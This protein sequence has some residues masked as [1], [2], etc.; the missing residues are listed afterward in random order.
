[1]AT[2]SQFQY[3]EASSLQGAIERLYGT[4]N[5]LLKIWFTL[6]QMGM[7][8]GA[9]PVLVTTSS[10][11]DALVRLFSFGNP[12]KALFVP[13]AHTPRFLKMEGDAGRSI[14]Q[15][16]IQ[17]WK[18]SGSVVTC[19]PTGFLDIS[20]NSNEQLL[21]S[22]TRSYPLGL[23]LGENGFALEAG[24]RVSL[25]ATS[26]S[27]WYFRQ[28][29]I[30]RDVKPDDL[31]EHLVRQMCNELKISLAEFAN[32]FVEDDLKIRTAKRP[33]ADS[34]LFRI[35][36][37]FLKEPGEVR[38]TVITEDFSQHSLRVRSMKTINGKPTWLNISPTQVL[39]DL[40][41]DHATA[42]L[43]Y[44]PPRTGKTRAV[45]VVRPRGATRET[46]QIHDG[47][48]Y[49]H[50]IE[51]F[52]PG[53]DNKWQWLSGPL[54]S[55]IESGKKT[56]VLEEINRTNLAQALGEVFSLIEDSYRGEAH[57][58]RLRSGAEF[59]VPKDVLFLMT[60]N[61]LDKSTEDIDDA[62]MGR[63]AAVEFPPRIEDLVLILN[64]RGVSEEVSQKLRDLF[65][66]ILEHYP[67]GPG[68]FA[69]FTKTADPLK[70]YSTRIRPVLANH[71]RDYRTESLD[72]IDNKVDALFGR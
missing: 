56:I 8:E 69:T 70:Y 33:L 49:D 52:R 25:P 16:S 19:D 23:G 38:A 35:C 41:K 58:I 53:D 61:N 15:T 17:R 4:A 28:S 71:F 54:K 63:F 34:E 30:P 9:P 64:D 1:M 31:A 44:G 21:V 43:L 42:V 24:Q 36:Q 68:Y 5:H 47:W 45:D 6:K 11:N 10:P 12:E 18:S 65:A 55:A 20:T 60:M 22:P 40:L 66:F 59:C 67:L 2:S 29:P 37:A 50:L 72:L 46:I 48:G 13:F 39:S 3:I 26:F 7:A 27:V 32:I 14:I 57:S 62:L 51:G